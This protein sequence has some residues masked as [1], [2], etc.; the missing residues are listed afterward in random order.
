MATVVAA[1]LAAFI[2]WMGGALPSRDTRDSGAHNGMTSPWTPKAARVAETRDST[3]ASRAD[4][5]AEKAPGTWVPTLLLENNDWK[6]AFNRLD[7]LTTL[8]PAE[9][10]FYKALIVETCSVY[11]QMVAAQDPAL[12]AA[13]RIGTLKEFAAQATA[14]IKDPRQRAATAFNMQRNIAN[15]CKGFSG[16]TISQADIAKA[17][18]QAADAGDLKAQARLLHFRQ[19]ETAMAHLEKRDQIPTGFSDPMT[20]EEREMLLAALFTGDPIAIRVA[21]QALSIGTMEQSLR[22]GP[23]QTDIGAH[24]EEVWTLVACQFGLECGPRNMAVTWNCQTQG[25]CADDFPGFLRDFVLTPA[26]YAFVE[27]SAQSIA[28]AIRRR[29]ASAFR[30]VPGPGNSIT[31]L[32]AYPSPIAIR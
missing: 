27:R 17:Y 9:R 5:A 25:K 26:E 15:A 7:A 11:P 32:G 31:S 4:R 14:Q 8:G 28:D 12:L 6:D 19:A 24:A 13:I 21:S 22:I 16:T 2:A 30:L 20:S 1:G 3:S 18:A 10:L 23:E 29:D